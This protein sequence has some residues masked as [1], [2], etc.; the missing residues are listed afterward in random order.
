[1]SKITPTARAPFPQVSH[2]RGAVKVDHWH[3]LGTPHAGRY[4]VRIEKRV[5]RPGR[6]PKLA[7][8]ILL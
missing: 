8:L 6:L 3:D 1:M 5:G 7:A 4:F 2:P